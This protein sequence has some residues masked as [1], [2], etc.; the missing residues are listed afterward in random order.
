M[1]NWCTFSQF[2]GI[3]AYKSGWLDRK[4]LIGGTNPNS[5]KLYMCSP[6]RASWM[7]NSRQSLLCNNHKLLSPTYLATF[8]LYGIVT[9]FGLEVLAISGTQGRQKT[10]GAFFKVTNI[11]LM[12]QTTKGTN[13]IKEVCKG[14][15]FTYVFYMYNSLIYFDQ[16]ST[17]LSS[18]VDLLGLQSLKNADMEKS[19]W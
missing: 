14:Y 16:R 13:N 4:T 8:H 12:M 10:Q 17:D 18:Q 3:L 15:V 9:K 7:R 2:P 5:I 11:T 1:P 19:M 6:C